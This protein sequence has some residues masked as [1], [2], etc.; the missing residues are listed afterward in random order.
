VERFCE[1]RGVLVGHRTAK[2]KKRVK[3]RGGEN[4]N[5]VRTRSDKDSKKQQKVKERERKGV[6]SRAYSILEGSAHL[7]QK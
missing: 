1:K 4:N 3:V 2:E 5:L 7:K 6:A